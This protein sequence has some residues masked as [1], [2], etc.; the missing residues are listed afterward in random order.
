MNDREHE[1]STAVAAAPSRLPSP[2][3]M[4][5]APTLRIIIMVLLNL[6]P[7]KRKIGTIRILERMRA[8]RLIEAGAMVLRRITA[9]QRL[10]PRYRRIAA[11]VAGAMSLHR[12]AS[13]ARPEL[14]A[15]HRTELL[16]EDFSDDAWRET[17]TLDKDDFTICQALVR[18]SEPSGDGKAVGA[19]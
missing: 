6:A 16:M 11:A 10:Q 7:G 3:Y 14:A 2:A 9:S 12:A 8:Q 18:P 17:F 5:V 15:V 19:F 13:Q 1:V 4:Q